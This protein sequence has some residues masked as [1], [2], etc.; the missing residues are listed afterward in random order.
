VG[1]DKIV[2]DLFIRSD[3][4]VDTFSTFEGK[5]KFFETAA[6]R[7][8]DNVFVLQHF[9]R[10]LLREGKFTSALAQ[11]ESAIAKDKT[12]SIRSLRHTRGLVLAAIA[13]TEAN[14]DLARKWLAQSEREFIHCISAKESDDYGHSGLASLYLAW[15]RRK[16]LSD[17]EGAEYLEKAETAVA[18]G[19]RV[20][21][22]KTA[23][24]IISSD[25]QK[26]LGNQPERISKLRQAVDADSASAI[27]RYLLARAYRDQGQ[28]RRTIE[29]LEPIITTDFT[30]VR[31]YI[32]YTRA[33]LEIGESIKKCAATISQCGLDGESDPA[34][35]GLYGGL[36]FMN[37]QYAN[38]TQL[39]EDAKEQNFSYEERIRKQY[40]P[41]DPADPSKRMRF[42]G[43]IEHAKPGLVLIQPDQGPVVIS[44]QTLVGSTLLQRG[45]KVS[46]DLSFSAKGPFAEHLQIS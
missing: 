15:S 5:V 45:Q 35:V 18:K 2:F 46:F 21:R 43:T 37:G 17:D 11:I 28:P 7:D 44:T 24:L 10:M 20:V 6:Q 9:A 3:E 39:W 8:P 4:I 34:F 40:I 42:T 32:E 30:Q 27:G 38:A 22:E 19:L 25:I 23:L 16:K 36:L 1:V 13:L 31:A 14:D 41:R 12:K 33:M 26:D 29:V